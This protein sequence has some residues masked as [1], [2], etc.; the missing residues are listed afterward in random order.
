MMA[1]VFPV[2]KTGLH[3]SKRLGLWVFD[4]V[5]VFPVS[6]TGLH[7]SWIPSSADQPPAAYSRSLRPGSIAAI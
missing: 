5:A 6:K 7:C 1:A 4:L 2:S 3:C